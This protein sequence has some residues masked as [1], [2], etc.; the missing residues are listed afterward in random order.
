[1]SMFKAKKNQRIRMLFPLMLV[2]SLF[3]ASFAGAEEL[4]EPGALTSKPP[5]ETSLIA[6]L[7]T[8]NYITS[9][10]SSASKSGNGILVS[11]NTRAN[12]AADFISVDVTLQK[13]TGSIW[14]DVRIITNSA[15][16]SSGVDKSLT[17][18]NLEKGYYYR[19]TSTHTVRMDGTVEKAIFNSSS[20]L[21]D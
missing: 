8:Y 9:F 11:G 13:W 19:T 10:Y 3:A 6:P 1:M 14:T 5:E 7:A 12:L 16:N 18:S 15:Y 2:F 17:V 4:L 21:F 20:Q